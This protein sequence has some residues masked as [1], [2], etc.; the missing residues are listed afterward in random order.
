MRNPVF[1]KV[2]DDAKNSPWHVKLKRYIRIEIH[3]IRCLG[4]R[5]YIYR[6]C[7]RKIKI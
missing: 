1:Q 6:K 3:C 4:L 5:R 2:L 7:I